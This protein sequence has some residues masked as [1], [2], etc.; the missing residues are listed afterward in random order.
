[1]QD[2]LNGNEMGLVA[3]WPLNEGYGDS[4]SDDSNHDHELALSSIRWA[5]GVHPIGV[6]REG[7][8]PA[9]PSVAILRDI[10]PN[11]FSSGTTVSFYMPEQGQVRAAITDLYG[12]HIRLLSDDVLP[13]GIHS[14]PWDGRTDIGYRMCSGTYFI[15]IVFDGK[16]E[17]KRLI[18]VR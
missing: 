12:R 6:D 3:Y 11:P 10:C 17:T 15:R 18:L 1:M 14:I 4:A 8:D 7:D 9:C 2:T 5:Q 13:S 16:T